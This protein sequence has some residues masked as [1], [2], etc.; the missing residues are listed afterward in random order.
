VW[1]KARSSNFYYLLVFFKL[2]ICHRHLLL[3]VPFISILP[4]VFPVIMCLEGSSYQRCD[5]C[6]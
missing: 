2:S 5:Q 4:S 6:S 1:S 3:H